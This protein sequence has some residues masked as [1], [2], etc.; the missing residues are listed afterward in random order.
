MATGTSCDDGDAD[1]ENDVIL[2]DGCTCE[3]TPPVSGPDCGLVTIV[4]GFESLTISGLNA[5]VTA[6]QVFDP[7]WNRVFK[8]AG[9]CD[10]DVQVIDGL[11]NNLIYFVKVSFFDASWNKICDVEGYYK[12][13]TTLGGDDPSNR[14]MLEFQATKGQ[15]QVDL[16]WGSNTGDLNDY[17]EI[18]RSQDGKHYETLLIVPNKYETAGFQTYLEKDIQPYNGVNYYRMKQVH[19]DGTYVFTGERKVVF[20]DD[21]NQFTVF[22][23]PTSDQVYIHLKSYSG[24][25]VNVE[26]YDAL[27]RLV[28]ARSL[29]NAP[30]VPL[31][32]D[33]SD[34]NEGTYMVSVKYK[35][36]KR[37]TQ[38]LVI[39]KE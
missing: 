18:Q 23:N 12:I 6:V 16:L 28:H 19:D 15:R 5:P 17:F 31:P 27:G 36:K 11:T 25:P 29:R 33:V 22:P 4:P 20:Q 38:R 30:V 3:G 39:I 9:D 26:F 13:E 21:F 7:N 2:A 10:P 35:G 34:F 8:C 32:F 1:T 14:R 37:V 24:L